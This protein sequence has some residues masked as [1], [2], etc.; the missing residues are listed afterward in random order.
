MGR[1]TTIKQTNVLPGSLFLF[2]RSLMFTISLSQAIWKPFMKCT[3]T[4]TRTWNYLVF[5]MKRDIDW[6]PVQTHEGQAAGSFPS[7]P[8]FIRTLA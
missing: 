7:L 3:H 6:W 8:G 1:G 4:H 2:Y 5:R